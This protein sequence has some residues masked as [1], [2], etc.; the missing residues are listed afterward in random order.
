LLEHNQTYSHN[1]L[2]YIPKRPE[3]VNLPT[4]KYNL[5]DISI[6]S[7]TKKFSIVE[8]IRDSNNHILHS[9]KEEIWFNFKGKKLKK[10]KLR[11]K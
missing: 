9:G 10:K 4:Y 6:E 1:A 2:S 11:S 8:S 5:N 3:I 7:H